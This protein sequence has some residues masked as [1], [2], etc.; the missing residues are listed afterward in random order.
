MLRKQREVRL[1]MELYIVV[2]H[3]INTQYPMFN[4]HIANEITIGIIRHNGMEI[5][6]DA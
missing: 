4:N 6:I 3:P 2:L 1:F 5:I